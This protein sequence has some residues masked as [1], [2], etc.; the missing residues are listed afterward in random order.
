MSYSYPEDDFKAIIARNNHPEIG[1]KRYREMEKEC[2]KMNG[3]GWWLLSGVS[4][5]NTLDDPWIKKFI[6]GESDEQE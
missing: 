3:R 5:R 6:K 2:L 4:L 1:T